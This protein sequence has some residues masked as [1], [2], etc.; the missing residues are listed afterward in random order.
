MTEKPFT[1]RVQHLFEHVYTYEQM[2]EKSGGTRSASWWRHVQ[3]EQ[4]DQYNPP[5]PRD[6]PGIAKL[7]GTTVEGVAAM[8]A[9]EFY[10]VTKFP[11]PRSDRERIFSRDLNALSEEDA[12]LVL[13]LVKRLGRRPDTE[14]TQLTPAVSNEE[15]RA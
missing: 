6:L 13:K 11:N 14:S 10:G 12:Q 7:F 1:R 15:A 4:T 5:P 8:I 3:L 9:Q 2:A